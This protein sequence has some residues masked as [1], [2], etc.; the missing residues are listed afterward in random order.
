VAK[1]RGDGGDLR[2]DALLNALAETTTASRRDNHRRDQ[3]ILALH[4]AGLSFR[5][6][7]PHTN[8]S[9]SSVYN[10]IKKALPE[11][12]EIQ[13]RQTDGWSDW[14]EWEAASMEEV[15]AHIRARVQP[16]PVSREEYEALKVEADVDE[17]EHDDKPPG[18]EWRHQPGL[19]V[20]ERYFRGSPTL[21]LLEAARPYRDC[22]LVGLR[23]IR[24]DGYDR[25]EE[26]RKRWLDFLGRMVLDLVRQEQTPQEAPDS[27]MNWYRA[28][29]AKVMA[30]IE[31]HYPDPP[32]VTDE[33]I[34]ALIDG[35]AT[36][37]QPDLQVAPMWQW[38]VVEVRAFLNRA[39][40]SRQDL[41]PEECA[42]QYRIGKLA[43]QYR[44]QR[45]G[46]DVFAEYRSRCL[47]ALGGLTVESLRAKQDSGEPS[48]T[49]C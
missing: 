43:E 23:R 31:D 26:L 34:Q 21:T 47:A 48:E 39:L 13:L 45:Q 9:P 3:L 33:E 37:S 17:S 44:L 46:V 10:I 11:E 40:S 7:A 28:S 12:E 16:G 38:S 5:E 2:V 29:P 27:L 25:P 1:P 19:L 49:E 42:S 35:L 32:S 20:V 30:Y 15:M 41:S 4:R 24:R 6:I 8:L 18:A 36:L 22:V 14:R